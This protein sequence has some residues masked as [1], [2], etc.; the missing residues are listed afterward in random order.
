MFDRSIVAIK[1]DPSIDEESLSTLMQALAESEDRVRHAGG[2]GTILDRVRRARASRSWRSTSRSSSPSESADLSPIVGDDPVAR[3]AL[4]EVLRFG[5][6]NDAAGDALAL[7]IEQ[8]AT[9][10]SLGSF[11]DDLL[12]KRRGGR[13][14]RGRTAPAVPLA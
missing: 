4:E 14:Q 11:L 10:E 3:R 2:V 9:V 12:D 8:V 1:I 5:G 13:R 6:K 7:S